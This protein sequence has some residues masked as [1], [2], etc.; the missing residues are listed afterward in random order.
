MWGTRIHSYI[1]DSSVPLVFAKNCHFAAKF[2]AN[3]LRYFPF[4]GYLC[5]GISFK[6]T[7]CLNLLWLRFQEGVWYQIFQSGLETL[8]TV[9]ITMGNG[10]SCIKE[11][12][13][14]YIKQVMRRFHQYHVRNMF[15][16]Q[17][18]PMHCMSRVGIA[19]HCK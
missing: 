10:I 13:C 3:A 7:D 11:V 16:L 12:I 14:N 18:Q 9:C 2:Q 19:I 17:T 4:H 8:Y 6:K 5:I 1:N 15:M